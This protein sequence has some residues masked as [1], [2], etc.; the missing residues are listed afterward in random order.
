MTYEVY[1][2]GSY[3]LQAIHALATNL[4]S[5]MSLTTQNQL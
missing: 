2:S 4:K 3:G 5:Q 1:T